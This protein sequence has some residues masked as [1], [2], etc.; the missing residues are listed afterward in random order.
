MTHCGTTRPVS[1][2]PNDPFDAARP[3]ISV[4]S[5]RLGPK[6]KHLVDYPISHR[7]TATGDLL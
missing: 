6:Q 2:V 1:G 7:H 3:W 4:S 5:R